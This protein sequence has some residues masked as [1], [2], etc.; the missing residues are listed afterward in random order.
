VNLCDK[1]NDGN[2]YKKS[3]DKGK[4]LTDETNLSHMMEQ[5]LLHFRKGKNLAQAFD[6]NGALKA[7]FKGQ[8]SG[9]THIDGKK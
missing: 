9:Q 2:G 6:V 5:K 8:M 4:T 7:S 3:K 1:C